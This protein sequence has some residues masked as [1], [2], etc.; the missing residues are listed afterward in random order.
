MERQRLALAT[1]CSE[2]KAAIWARPLTSAMECYEIDQSNLRIAAF[3][4]QVAHESGLFSIAEENLRYSANGL[5]AVFSKYFTKETAE[6]YAKQPEK[7][8]NK[9]YGNRMGNGD[10]ASGDGWRFRGRGL[11]QLTGK[12][13]YIACG[14][15]MGIDLVSAPEML[16][17]P[18]RSALAAG[19]FWDSRKLND[20]ADRGDFEKVTR[21]INGGM[22]GFS[23]RLRIYE[24]AKL[25][26][27]QKES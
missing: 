2:Q 25:V 13:N 27:E 12:T 21:L 4:A 26:L 14:A 11:I 16:L 20:W 15:A 3:L 1:G 17:E 7:I 5:L 19:W 18:D 6:A 9:V 8:A 24:N 23:D 22:I 10:E